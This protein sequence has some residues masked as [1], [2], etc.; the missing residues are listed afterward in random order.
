[1]II[2]LVTRLFMVIYGIELCD[3]VKYFFF[4]V[5]V[6]ET[7]AELVAFIGFLVCGQDEKRL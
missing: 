1:M 2:F 4:L 3:F 6:C 7:V 5:S